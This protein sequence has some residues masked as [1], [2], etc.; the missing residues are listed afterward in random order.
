M[1][2]LVTLSDLPTMPISAVAALPPAQLM[3]LSED[4]EA[5]IETARTTKAW[6][7]GALGLKYGERATAALAAAGKGSGAI[8]FDDGDITVVVETPKKVAWDQPK[9]A[10]LVSLMIESSD[11]P[12]EFIDIAYRVP[13]RRHA[14]WPSQIRSAFEGARTVRNGKPAYRLSPNDEAVR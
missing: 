8:R 10:A 5:A 14:A 4:A 12:T 1:N 6:L 3:L 2:T 11:A 9:L 7:D 13:E